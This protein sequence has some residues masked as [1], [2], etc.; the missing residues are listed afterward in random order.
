MFA[1]IRLDAVFL[2]GLVCCFCRSLSVVLRLQQQADKTKEDVYR[3][4]VI[5]L[6]DEVDP[7]Q[8]YH[9]VSYIKQGSFNI[10]NFLYDIRVISYDAILQRCEMFE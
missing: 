8:S 7:T 3:Y 5:Q 4:Q 1:E 10:E 9:K 6:P 2:S